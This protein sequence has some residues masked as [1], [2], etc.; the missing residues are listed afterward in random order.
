VWAIDQGVGPGTLYIYDGKDMDV[1]AGSAVPD[2]YD[3][4]VHVSPLCIAETGTAPV[5]GHMLELNSTHSHAILAFVATG[6]VVFFNT[7]TR[8]PVRCIDVGVQRRHESCES[9]PAVLSRLETL[10]N[11]W[12]SNLLIS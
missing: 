8:Q 12:S 5:R 1:R 10:D 9:Q 4:S 7:A 2:V 6:H 11:L 3:L